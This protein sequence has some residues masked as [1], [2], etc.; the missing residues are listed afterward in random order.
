MQQSIVT[1]HG[2]ALS[3]VLA[4]CNRLDS[5]AALPQCPEDTL[6][7][8]DFLCTV[9]AQLLEACGGF[10]A[11]DLSTSCT[12]TCIRQVLSS[13]SQ[14]ASAQ[15]DSV[16]AVDVSKPCVAEMMHAVAP[17]QSLCNAVEGLLE[18]FPEQPMLEKLQAICRRVLG[19]L[20]C[21]ACAVCSCL[22]HLHLPKRSV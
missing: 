7:I 18:R 16:G 10:T 20:G 9:G 6:H 22:Q 1:A 5:P 13:M 19:A 17:V 3:H 14:L 12:S 21:A 4:Q 2:R 11:T 15:H 8:A